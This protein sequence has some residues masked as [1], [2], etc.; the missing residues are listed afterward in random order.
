MTD[1]SALAQAQLVP[2]PYQELAVE[3]VRLEVDI[4]VDLPLVEDSPV[5]HVQLHATSAEDQTILLATVRLRP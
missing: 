3:L 1:S 5:D 4:A 2:V